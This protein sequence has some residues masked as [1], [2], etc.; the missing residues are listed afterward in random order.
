V[1]KGS[2]ILRLYIDKP[3]GVD[4]NDC[5]RVSRAVETVID[6]SDTI[7]EKYVLEVSSPGIE[8]KL[9]KDKHFV[10]YIGEKV[11]LR[12]YKPI[13]G[14]KKY[15][16]LLTQA[17]ADKITIA[18]INGTVRDFKRKDISACRLDFFG[19]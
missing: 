14:I 10:R 8:R 6:A 3:G 12:L 15:N 19:G 16:G 18:D 1:E 5:E 9:R 4:L 7:R 2:R 13:D 17:D 11:K